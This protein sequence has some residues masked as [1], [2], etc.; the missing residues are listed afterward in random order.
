MD[1]LIAITNESDIPPELCDT[2][3]GMLL[4]YHNLQEPFQSYTQARLLIGMCMDNRKHLLIP[5]NFAYII[6]AGGANLRHSEFK[7]SYALSMA[8]IQHIAVIG[9]NNCGMV[10]LHERR[11]EFIKGLVDTAG[12]T[13]EH[14]AAH[15]DK[16][17]PDS[18]IGNAIDFAISEAKRLE[19]AYP[20]IT[21][22]PMHY[23]VEDNKI[24]LIKE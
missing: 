19:E 4:R 24:Y 15:F 23:L 8:N 10:D 7:V 2:P 21:A 14:A 6:R 20:K 16:Y 22:V 9:H 11:E 3:I 13:T 17:A 12:W 5:D 1:R 18:E